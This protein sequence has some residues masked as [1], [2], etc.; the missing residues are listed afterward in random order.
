MRQSYIAPAPRPGKCSPRLP[1]PLEVGTACAVTRLHVR[2]VGRSKQ[3]KAAPVSPWGSAP[4]GVTGAR[5]TT[6]MSHTRQ[7]GGCPP[8]R[9]PHESVVE[10]KVG[11][12]LGAL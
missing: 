3:A 12:P 9:G 2:I 1:C 6:S 5:W 4:T 7:I 8:V 11:Y 10:T